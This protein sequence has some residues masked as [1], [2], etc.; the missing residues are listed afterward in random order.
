MKIF[1]QK[2]AAVN[3]VAVQSEQFSQEVELGKS[4]TFDLTLE[5]Y[6]GTTNT[7]SLE[8]VNLPPS[9]T[10]FF[11]DPGGQARLSQFKFTQSTNT[12]K[13][14]LEVALPD[15]PAQDVVMDKAI[16]F[17]V[18]V[19]PVEQRKRLG[20]LSAKIWT[21][22]EIE[23][24]N[25]GYARLEVMP[26]G[27]G[28]LLVRSPQL[29]HSISPGGSVSM[30]VDVVNEGSRR[31][32]N[33]EIKVDPPLNWTKTID[34]TVVPVLDIGQEHRITLGFT[35]PPGIAPGRYEVRLR[36]SALSETTPINA[37][38]KTVTVEV[39]SETSIFGTAVLV[40]VILGLIAG[41]VYF[42]MRLSKR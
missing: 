33:V 38:D 37:E 39:Q 6:S 17:Y 13:A 16:T 5:L 7:F 3:R 19:L 27:Q 12:R 40:I 21:L 34:P 22:Q 10:R 18:L 41:V 1:L 42:G 32:D 11:K 14:A 8:V 2:D 31:L 15:R 26:R 30:S 35:P 36:T 28:K 9:I 24:L 29:F 25:A 4:A 20:D 23:A